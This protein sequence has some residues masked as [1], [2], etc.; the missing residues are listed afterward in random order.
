MVVKSLP[1]FLHE[2]A[3]WS[4]GF[5]VLGLDEAGRGAFA[6]PLAVGGVIFS[7][8]ISDKVLQLGVNDS[9][10]LSPK[11]REEL[12]EE[13]KSNSLFSHI[14]FIDLDTINSI[15]IG[16]ATLL[17]MKNIYERAEKTLGNIFC[18]IDAFKIPEVVNQKA[19]IH[20]DRLSVSI[21]AASILAK[22]E[23]DRI[24][25]K[26]ALELPD[27]GFEI[28]KGYGTLAHRNALKNFGPS[29]YHRTQF[30]SKYI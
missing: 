11:K 1:T 17:G 25:S 19:I 21:A 15:G 26:L 29:I 28:H 13:I 14:E 6:G 8:E 22:V 27:Y 20:G 5:N 18:M 7:K 24:M 12:F 10:L 4:N 23:R 2:T 16:K 30:I 3:M 9:K